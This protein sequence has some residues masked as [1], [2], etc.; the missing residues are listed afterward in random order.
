[1]TEPDAPSPR[2]TLIRVRSAL[3]ICLLDNPE[4]LTLPARRSVLE[5]RIAECSRA[6][7]QMDAGNG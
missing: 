3:R 7:A 1:M 5:R 6:I 2:E 4:D